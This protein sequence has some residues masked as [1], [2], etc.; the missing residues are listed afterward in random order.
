MNPNNIK[1]GIDFGKTIGLIEND[2]PY[3]DCISTISFLKNKFGSENIYI[4][5]KAK[6][7]MSDKI[8]SWLNRINFY[9]RTS[10]LKDN[11]I[12]CENY[13]D[14]ARIVEKL[15]INVFIDDHIKVIQSMILLKQIK[16]IIWFNKNVDIK[17]IEKKFRKNIYITTKWS[18]IIKIIKKNC[19]LDQEL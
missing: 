19:L 6:K 11:V 18:S 12:F 7:E 14:K 4:I 10:F 13:S 8:T 5:S 15:K 1:I 2:S 3:P 16:L 17:L 9:E